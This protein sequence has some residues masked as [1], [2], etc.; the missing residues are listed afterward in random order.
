MS[1]LLTGQVGETHAWLEVL[2]PR[3]GWLGVDPT[4]G[5]LF[6]P[7][8]D[9]IKLA[10]GRDYSDVSPVAGSFLSKGAAT[11]YAAISAVRFAAD[12]EAGFDGALE[13]LAPAYVVKNG[14]ARR[15]ALLNDLHAAVEPPLRPSSSG[16]LRARYP[17]R[18]SPGTNRCGKAGCTGMTRTVAPSLPV[19]RHTA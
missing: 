14:I 11:E 17:W 5:V 1:G 10:V 9:Y 12:T 7:A 2:H 19:V 8:C 13:L 4:R 6:P 15:K 3:Q 16:N 18:N